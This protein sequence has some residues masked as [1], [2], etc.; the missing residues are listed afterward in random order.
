MCLLQMSPLYNFDMSDDLTGNSIVEFRNYWW[1]GV[2]T[3]LLQARGEISHRV[4]FSL[5]FSISNC[6][7]KTLHSYRIL[8]SPILWFYLYPQLHPLSLV[9]CTCM[10]CIGHQLLPLKGLFF[11]LERSV[12][13]E[14]KF[15]VSMLPNCIL[16]FEWD[17]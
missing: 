12:L 16:K 11:N 15:S 4:E 3:V 13:L 8:V 9:M 5:L 1:M 17:N 14:A 6:S 7:C 10:Q 2:C